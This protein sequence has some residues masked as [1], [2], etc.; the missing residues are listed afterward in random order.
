LSYQYIDVNNRTASIDLKMTEA[1]M[2]NVYISASLI[3]AHT[4]SDIP[5]TVAHGY[6]SIKVD[7]K[8]RKIP[9]EIVAGKSTRSKTHQKVTVKAA[10][11]SFVTLA[12]VDNGVLQVSGFATPDPYDHFY[13]K[14]A[15]EVNGFD[16]YPLLF[17]ELRAL[18]STGGDGELSMDKRTN[19]M[20]SKRIKVVS[21]WSGITTANGNGESNFEFDIPQFSGE[22]RL[23]AVAYK[24]DQFGSNEA[25]MKVADP[26][27]L[28]SSLPRFMSPG[29]TVTMPVIIT[30]TTN[31][32]AT[33]SAS[34]SVTGPLQ[35]VGGATQ[36]IS[37]A[38]NSENRAVFR[39]VAASAITTGKIRVEVQGMG[40]KFTEETEIGVRPAAPLQVATG[41]G[42]LNGASS[43]QLSIPVKDYLPGSTDYQLVIS[44]SPALELGK[45]F[46][47]LVQYPYGCTEQTVS[48]AFPQLYYGDIAEQMGGRSG[49]ATNA[50]ANANYNVAEAI[51]KIK[52]RQL[53]NGGVT[54]WDGEGT[55]NWWTSVYA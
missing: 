21:Y 52:L 22:I 1:H 37:L 45:Q 16:L 41:S 10:P 40:E 24:N 36:S 25:A 5:L 35:V 44:R 15:L 2:P 13:A 42:S 51:R 26:L 49:A 33:A 32:A 55:E 8:S 14:K 20:P 47:Y 7:A 50:R 17:P 46:R 12:A 39:V 19:P 38:A 48:A 3:K 6:Q 43:Q 18:S 28:S 29:D 9:V 4:V 27:V 30:N 23:M 53:Y 34:V 31:K 54:L 11:G